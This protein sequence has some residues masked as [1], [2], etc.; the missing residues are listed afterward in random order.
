MLSIE[1]SLLDVPDDGSDSVIIGKR[2]YNTV[3]DVAEILPLRLSLT[4]GTV[5]SMARGAPDRTLAWRF[6]AKGQPRFA[7]SFREGRRVVWARQ[8][9]ASATWT[10]MDESD[11]LT[12]I[13]EPLWVDSQDKVWVS[14]RDAQGVRVL[15]ALDPA[16]GKPSAKPLISTPGFDVSGQPVIDPVTRRTLGYHLLTDAET[17][18]W[19]DPNMVKLQ[20][21]VDDKLPGLRNRISCAPCTAGQAVVLVHSW[22]DLDP[23]RYTLFHQ[24]SGRWQSV[25]AVHPDIDPS[26]SATV[27]FHRIKA[28]DGR[29]LPVWV[30]MPAN[31]K[32]GERRPT[33]VL[34]H[35]GPWVRGGSW[36][37]EPMQQFL[38]SRGYV[39]IEPEFRGSTGYGLEHFA[40]GFKQWGG[41]MQDDVAD[42]LQWAIAQG[43]ADPSKACIAGAS[44]GGYATLM[45]LAKYPQL[46]RCGIAW[47]AVTDVGLLAQARFD[48]DLPEEFRHFGF[49]VLVG[50]PKDEALM[51]SLSPVH[52]AAEIKA[53]LMLAFGGVD[54]RVPIAHGDRMRDA[55]RAAGRDPVWVRYDAEGHGW[56]LPANQIDFAKR[57]EAFLGQH[58]R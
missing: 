45:G 12:S 37:W 27:D 41:A 46:Y 32:P 34:V 1:H 39:V 25:G 18:V 24:A 56:F 28:R 20:K 53:P 57:V 4:Q 9:G 58:L 50:D 6:D 43:F 23:G 30:T 29:D 55:L 54:R 38:A 8:S 19:F 51:R 42:A 11:S 5:D 33:V 16:T 10:Q 47:A 31:A 52:R 14:A 2:V 44:Y 13:W 7:I 3:D 22:S 40:E 48:S 21:L 15:S 36:R 49:P 35:G 17:T 26:L